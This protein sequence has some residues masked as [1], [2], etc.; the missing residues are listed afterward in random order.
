LILLQEIIGGEQT[1]QATEKRFGLDAHK[2]PQGA[3]LVATMVVGG[4]E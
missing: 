4:G 3:P 2:R 1:S